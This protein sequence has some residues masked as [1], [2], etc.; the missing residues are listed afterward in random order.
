MEHI[1]YQTNGYFLFY[2]QNS[3]NS[4]SIPYNSHIINTDF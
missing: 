4:T 3:R 2:V 1:G